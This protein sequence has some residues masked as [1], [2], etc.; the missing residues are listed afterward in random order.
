MITCV[1]SGS[2]HPYNTSGRRPLIS[3]L[4]YWTTPFSCPCLCVN[5]ENTQQQFQ[6][7]LHSHRDHFNCKKCFCLDWKSTKLTVFMTQSFQWIKKRIYKWNVPETSHTCPY[8]F[9]LTS[10]LFFWSWRKEL[11]GF[12]EDACCSLDFVSHHAWRRRESRL[13]SGRIIGQERSSVAGQEYI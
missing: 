6:P 10:S 1:Q 8:F 4:T 13:C 11:P 9:R 3:N 12:G 7:P 2:V 5:Q